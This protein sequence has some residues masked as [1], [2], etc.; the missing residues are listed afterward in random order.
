MSECHKCELGLRQCNCYGQLD[1]EIAR[2]KEA[3]ERRNADVLET[4]RR[5]QLSFKNTE[6]FERTCEVLSR[7]LNLKN[8]LLAEASKQNA[9]LQ[10][11]VEWCLSKG[12]GITPKGEVLI[13][14]QK[15]SVFIGCQVPAEFADIIF[16]K[17][18]LE[19]GDAR[20]EPK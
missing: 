12:A 15:H 9:N 17:K 18:P 16:P 20:Q 14:V 13:P 8:H 11:A 1:K 19:S 4:D 7:D 6:H 3:L 5:L 2:L 10:R